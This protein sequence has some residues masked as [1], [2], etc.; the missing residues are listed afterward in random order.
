MLP[1]LKNIVHILSVNTDLIS[2]RKGFVK[3]LIMNLTVSR[4][5]VCDILA[6]VLMSS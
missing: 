4:A 2:H 3:I 1:C 6:N 5:I